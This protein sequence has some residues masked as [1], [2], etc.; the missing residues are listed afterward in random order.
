[1]RAINNLKRKLHYKPRAYSGVISN[2]ENAKQVPVSNFIKFNQQGFS[3]CLWHTEKTPSMFYYK[4][5][6]RIKCFGGCGKSEDVIGVVQELY[7]VGVKEA[8]KIILK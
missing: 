1:M 3:S 7:K 8:I 2:L 4:N 6:N 5:Q